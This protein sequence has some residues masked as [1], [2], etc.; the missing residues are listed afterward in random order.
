MGETWLLSIVPSVTQVVTISF[1]RMRDSYTNPYE[2]KR[3]ESF[4]IFVCTKRIHDTN[5]RYESLR[6]TNPDSRIRDFRIRK[7]SDSRIF[8][9]KDSFRAIVLRIRKDS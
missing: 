1:I 2:S 4:E 6:F 5:P 3:I 8:I 7:D 9:F